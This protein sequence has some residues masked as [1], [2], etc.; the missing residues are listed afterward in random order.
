MTIDE[1]TEQAYASYEDGKRGHYP[2]IFVDKSGNEYQLAGFE[3]DDNNE[4]VY[5]RPV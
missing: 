5:L 4:V 3:N 1:I 2:V